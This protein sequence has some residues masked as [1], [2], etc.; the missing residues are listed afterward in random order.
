[1]FARLATSSVRYQ[2]PTPWPEYRD[3]AS[4]PSPRQ[5]HDPLVSRS[6]FRASQCVGSEVESEKGKIAVTVFHIFFGRTL[7]GL[8]QSE[9]WLNKTYVGL[10]RH[11]IMEDNI[12]FKF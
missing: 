9:S 3:P 7:H 5:S 10:E 12:Y 11:H 6:V 1:M 2:I 4:S 8:V